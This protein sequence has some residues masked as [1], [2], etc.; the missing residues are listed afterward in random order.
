MKIITKG[1]D[2][3]AF[4]EGF[5]YISW[6][7]SKNIVKLI[8][9]INDGLLI[10]EFDNPKKP[11]YFNLTPGETKLLQTINKCTLTLIDENNI[12]YNKGSI[13]FIAKDKN[14]FKN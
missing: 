6:S 5:S 1:A 7:S 4:Q 2:T 9:N 14:I 12:T 3:S 11:F 10:R 13:I 8:I